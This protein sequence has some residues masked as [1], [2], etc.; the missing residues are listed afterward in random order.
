MPRP[1]K[2]PNIDEQIAAVEA[3]ISEL[4]SKLKDLKAQKKEADK[5]R[6]LDAISA[7]G[8]SV[9]D[10]ISMLAGNSNGSSEGT[11]KQEE[12]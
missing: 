10:V 6:L 7:S 3:Q 1:K 9:D 11:G 12:N 5:R 2:N 4:Q 8:K